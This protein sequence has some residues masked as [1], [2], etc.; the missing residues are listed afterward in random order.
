[1]AD[2]ANPTVPNSAGVPAVSGG[3]TT[4]APT[5][6]ATQDNVIVV[7]GNTA[8]W[9]IFLSGTATSPLK[10]DSF[11]EVED[12]KDYQVGKAPVEQGGFMSYNKVETPEEI[13]VAVAKGGS[14]TTLAAF[15]N[16]ISN[17]LGSLDLYSV[18]TPGRTYRNMNLVHRD[19]HRTSE[20]GVSLLTVRL[21]F[22]EI[23][24]TVETAFTNVTADTAAN[25]V[26]QGSVQGATP[27][28]TQTP[29]SAPQ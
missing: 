27:S 20:H 14:D 1:M 9:G 13:T 29:G 17:M 26:N 8:R 18:I 15:M 23:R 3:A 22:L 24:T 11:V 6:A 10:P 4:T 25:N 21:H 5:T 16:D 2:P 19:Q 28:A 12:A 7:R